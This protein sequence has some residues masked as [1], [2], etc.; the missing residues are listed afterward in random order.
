[1]SLFPHSLSRLTTAEGM[2]VSTL[3]FASRGGAILGRGVFG[4]GSPGHVLRSLKAVA[5]LAVVAEG[6]AVAVAAAFK[7]LDPAYLASNIA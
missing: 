6:L 4:A 3:G 7:V 2:A 5:R 1:M